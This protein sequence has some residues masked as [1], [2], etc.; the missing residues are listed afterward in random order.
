MDLDAERRGHT[1][2]IE[3]AA[4]LPVVPTGLRL[5]QLV[6]IGLLVAFL[7]PGGTLFAVVKLD[8][9]V[10]SGEQIE[11]LARV[12]LLVS[13]P[14]APGEGEARPNRR[15]WLAAGMVAGVFAVYAAVLIVRMV[16][17]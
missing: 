9:R 11:R 5:S 6:I 17:T 13:I 16:V 15:G 2:R 10:R 12:P 14:D 4:E 3:E 7:L 1:M 8:P